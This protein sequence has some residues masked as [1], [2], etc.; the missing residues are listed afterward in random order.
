MSKFVTTIKNNYT[1]VSAS[2]NTKKE[3]TTPYSSKGGKRVIISGE[4]RSIG[5]RHASQFVK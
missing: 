5:K 3:F 4:N 1:V 2:T